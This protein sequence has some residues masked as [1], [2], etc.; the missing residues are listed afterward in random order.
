MFVRLYDV[1]I[2]PHLCSCAYNRT[3]LL[4]LLQWSLK[5]VNGV[6]ESAWHSFS[7]NTETLAFF[8]KHLSS[9]SHVFPFWHD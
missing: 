7:E 6:I 4:V 8:L 2:K 1:H 5:I 3:L 9:F